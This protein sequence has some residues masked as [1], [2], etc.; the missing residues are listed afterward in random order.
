MVAPPS[1][2]AHRP[3][4]CKLVPRLERVA[5][6]ILTSHNGFITAFPLT[7]ECKL[8]CMD[9]ET[10]SQLTPATPS[11]PPPAI[12]FCLLHLIMPSHHRNLQ[13]NSPPWSLACKRIWHNDAHFVP[14]GTSLPDFFIASFFLSNSNGRC[15]CVRAPPCLAITT[16]AA[17]LIG[18]DWGIFAPL[19][20]CVS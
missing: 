16:D 10:P 15:N 11:A 17:V 5:P 3:M 1:C 13:T 7:T 14:L 20:Q 12:P 8:Y 6:S 19:R 9:F 2:C 4:C 18:A